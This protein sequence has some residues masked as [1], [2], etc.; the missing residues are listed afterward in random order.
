MLVAGFLFA[1]SGVF[2]K[3]GS[4]F[5][6][7]AEMAMYRSLFSLAVVV[8]IVAAT[9]GATVRTQ[10]ATGHVMRSL[11]GSVSLIGY[12]YAITKLPLATAQTLNYTSPLFLAIATTVVLG[13]RFSPWLLVAIVLG[14]CGVALLLR[15]T[16]AAGSEGAAVIGLMSGVFSAW[17]YLSVR[18]LGRLGEPDW[19]VLFYFATIA[20]AMCAAWQV[21]MGEFHA[22]TLQGGAILLALGLCGTLAQL[23]MTRAYRTGNTLVVGAFS[24]SSIVFA[25]VFTVAIWHDAIG[26]LAYAGMAIIIAS[27]VM[28]MRVEKKEQVEEAGFES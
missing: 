19:R 5:F 15:P 22:I 28:A 13:E 20:S 3:L 4:E 25:T 16:F 23:A 24:Y 6:G 10:F 7:P 27:G 26:P 2:V 8:G 18:T 21:T 12:F 14:F 1:A 11:V 17:A 9:P